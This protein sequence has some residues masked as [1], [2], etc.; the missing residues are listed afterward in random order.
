MDTA[1]VVD[2]AVVDQA[3]EAAP[4][5]EAKVAPFD[6]SNDTMDRLVNNA[7]N[8]HVIVKNLVTVIV[9]NLAIVQPHL[10]SLEPRRNRCAAVVANQ[11]IKRMLA[12]A[13]TTLTETL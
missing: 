8:P 5:V 3:V 7:K 2:K 6:P 13:N 12:S 4:A 1:V 9:K 11:D 10:L